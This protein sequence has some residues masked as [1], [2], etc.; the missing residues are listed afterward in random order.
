M[1]GDIIKEANEELDDVAAYEEARKDKSSE[2]NP[3]P[4][5]DEE[6]ESANTRI[7]PDSDSMESRG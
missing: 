5:T 2:K 1:K 4:V 6:V 3:K 7:N